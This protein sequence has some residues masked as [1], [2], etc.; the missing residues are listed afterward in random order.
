MPEKTSNSFSSVPAAD[1]GQPLPLLPL[2]DG[3]LL[4]GTVATIPVGRPASVAL[5]NATTIGGLV[6]VAVQKDAG[7]AD[8]CLADL[9]EVAVVARIAKV[10]RMP[11][12]YQV[13]LEG[14]AR[15]QLRELQ[16]TTPYLIATT[17][18]PFF[19]TVYYSFF[20]WNLTIPTEVH[21]FVGFGNYSGLLTDPQNFRVL[22]NTL[23]LT[24]GTLF[25]TLVLGG[26]L[27]LLLNRPFI[28]RTLLRTLLISS[29]LVMP[30][31]TAV[32]W[33]NMLL[34]PVFGP[35]ILFGSGGQLVEVY[36]DRS[37]ALPPLNAT[38]A[39]G[40]ATPA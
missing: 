34:N 39:R 22:L 18:V 31:V 17:Q 12:G 20:Q 24:G 1:Q 38:L 30:V 16:Q 40:L 25:I 23:V 36:K 29:F 26:L 27:A 13:T 6:A 4:P 33:K 2:R 11:R 14:L 19:M 37:L 3:V 32:V 10:Q 5:V 7:V 21:P 15:I 28:G 8:P 35:V 9:H